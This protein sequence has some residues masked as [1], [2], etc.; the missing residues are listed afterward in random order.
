MRDDMVAV[1]LFRVEPMLTLTKAPCDSAAPDGHPGTPGILI[2]PRQGPLR[3][4]HLM[5]VARGPRRCEPSPGVRVFADSH[6]VAGLG[7]GTNQGRPALADV[8]TDASAAQI[9]ASPEEPGLLDRYPGCG[10]AVA[11]G[12]HGCL[13]GLRDGRLAA[14]RGAAGFAVGAD[15]WPAV[16]GSFVHGWWSARMPLEGLATA[17]VIVGRYIGRTENGFGC[18]HVA[19]RGRILLARRSPWSTGGMSA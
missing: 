18:F 17:S 14:I 6:V 2:I 16:Y 5:L 10:V 7:D 3:A 12:R 11:A 1:R 15:P 19:G 4:P 8:L 13:A 9:V